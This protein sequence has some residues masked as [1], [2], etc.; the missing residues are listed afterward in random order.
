MPIDTPT[1]E[2]QKNYLWEHFKFNA[3]QR[4]KAF[5]FYVLLSVFADGGVYAIVEKGREHAWH[6]PLGLFLMLLALVFYALDRRS[7]EL[8]QLSEN[9]LRLY[10]SHLPPVARLF[11]MD[12]G[13]STKLIRYTNAFL[14][15]YV[16]QFLF[17]MAVVGVAARRLLCHT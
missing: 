10:E 4:L 8:L 14:V 15:L 6:L 13:K 17:G 7:R 3:D 12:S 11:E 2:Q 9:G 5:H 16:A 1:L